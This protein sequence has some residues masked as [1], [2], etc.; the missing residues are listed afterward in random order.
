MKLIQVHQIFA[1]GRSK[2]ILINADHLDM[3]V[4]GEGQFSTLV[5]AGSDG[6]IRIL[7]TIPEVM[8]LVSG[9]HEP[10]TAS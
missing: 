7:E 3:V 9:C 4:P 8:K 1:A 5:F 6:E 10:V 2:S